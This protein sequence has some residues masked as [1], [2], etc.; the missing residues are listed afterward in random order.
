[1]STSIWFS[2]PLG[3][4]AGGDVAVAVAGEAMTSGRPARVSQLLDLV[5]AMTP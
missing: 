5:E 3:T 1:M 2:S 4:S